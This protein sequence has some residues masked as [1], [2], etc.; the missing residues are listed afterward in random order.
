MLPPRKKP[1]SRKPKRVMKLSTPVY[2]R[3]PTPRPRTLLPPPKKTLLERS[4]NITRKIV[5]YL[6]LITLLLTMYDRGKK[7]Q[8]VG[9]NIAWG[10]KRLRPVDVSKV[11]KL[12]QG[13]HHRYEY[14]EMI[15]E[16][17]N[18]QKIKGA[19]RIIT[20]AKRKLYDARNNNNIRREIMR[21]KRKVEMKNILEEEDRQK[22]IHDNIYTNLEQ[23]LKELRK[24]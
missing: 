9:K 15:R 19:S 20:N 13:N 17:N 24:M 6:A 5:P 22:R 16:L 8:G 14:D 21:S 23:R 10:W 3:Y 1:T 12:L 11:E 18:L 7:L 2:V 4:Q